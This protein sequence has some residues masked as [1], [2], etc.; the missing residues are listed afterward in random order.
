V[1]AENKSAP[2]KKLKLNFIN[3]FKIDDSRQNMYWGKNKDEITYPAA[4]VGVCMNV[5]SL[6]Q[7]FMGAGEQKSVKG[8]T[9]DIMTLGL[10]P[11]RKLVVTGSLGA[12][13]LILVWDSDSMEVI[14]RANLNRNTRAVVAIRFSKDGKYFF[15]ADKHNDSNVYCFQAND[16]KLLG[17]N[18]C[19]SDPVFDGETGDNNTYATATKRGIY[20]FEMGGELEKKRGLFSGHDM[21]SMI[22]ITYS[23]ENKCFFSGTAKGSIYVWSGNSCSKSVPMHKGSVM[24]L[25]WAC[26]KLLSSGSKDGLIKISSPDLETIKTFEISNSYAK[27]LDLLNGKLLAG[28]SCGRIMVFDENTADKKEVMNGHSQGEAWGLAIGGDGNIF[29]TADD[30]SVICFNPK[31]FKSEGEGVINTNPGRRRR[32][33]GA[34]TLSRLPP[35]QH[36]RAVAVNK[37]GHVMIGTN[38]GEV[39][40]RTCKVIFDNNIGF[41]QKSVFRQGC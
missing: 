1:P 15:C 40:V 35:N 37:A 20:F 28:T 19:G 29:T 17:Q 30:N 14:A 8:H 9:D 7:R 32:I 39:S 34:S 4:A 10:S 23:P 22:T 18:K 11:D 36:S 38:D 31:T 2:E 33:G 21:T 16:G 5:N 27:S 25:N 6:K 26:G 3:G 24:G 12:R 13:P 41:K